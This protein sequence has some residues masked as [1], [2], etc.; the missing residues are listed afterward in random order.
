MLL[1]DRSFEKSKCLYDWDYKAVKIP[2]SRKTF[3]RVSGRDKNGHLPYLYETDEVKMN[4][5][6]SSL[7]EPS[8]KKVNTAQTKLFGLKSTRNRGSLSSR[9]SG[10][11]IDMWK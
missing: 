7:C 4:R 11:T 6:R 10:Y 5:I 3:L 2:A 1:S 9:L 8:F